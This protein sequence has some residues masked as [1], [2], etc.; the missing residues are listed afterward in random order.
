[1][2]ANDSASVNKS[3]GNDCNI[4]LDSSKQVEGR[5]SMASDEF[6]DAIDEMEAD[7]VTLIDKRKHGDMQQ[8]ELW[9]S[10]SP[11]HPEEECISERAMKES[12]SM[13]PPHAT[14][15]RL[16]GVD[17]DDGMSDAPHALLKKCRRVRVSFSGVCLS[18]ALLPCIEQISPSAEAEG[19][20]ISFQ[21]E[22]EEECFVPPI[23]WAIVDGGRV[24]ES[25][26]VCERSINKNDTAEAVQSLSTMTG[27]NSIGEVERSGGA[28]PPA[29]VFYSHSSSRSLLLAWKQVHIRVVCI[30]CY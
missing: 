24:Y 17:E 18:V 3:E 13:P 30:I 16:W 9:I 7:D 27:E 8:E 12:G 26:P 10:R 25:S 15:K 20:D 11:P 19:S 5:E 28:T 2:Q 21:E 22:E 4:P 1:M 14:D 23:C 6:Y 29:D